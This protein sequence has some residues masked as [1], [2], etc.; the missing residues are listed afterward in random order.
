MNRLTPDLTEGR[1]KGRGQQA[2]DGRRIVRRWSGLVTSW[3]LLAICLTVP[4]CVR[5]EKPADLVI[6]NGAE[7][8]SLDPA[9]VTGQPEL[10]IVQGLF[11]GLTRNDPVTA[12]AVPGL[13]ERWEVSSNN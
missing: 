11:E 4:G 5:Q 1:K 9:I 10:R 8:E 12:A 2:E 13:A 7:P 3:V 6:V